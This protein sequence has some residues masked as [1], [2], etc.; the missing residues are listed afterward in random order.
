MGIS[1]PGGGNGGGRRVGGGYLHRLPSENCRTIY[2]NKAHSVSVSGVG[3][4]ARSSVIEAVART[5]GTRSRGGT[6]D[7]LG[8]RGGNEIG[9]R[10]GEEAEREIY[11]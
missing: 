8:G 6:G 3:A 11:N 2:R 9:A 1:C 10:S 4:A 5:G 7:G